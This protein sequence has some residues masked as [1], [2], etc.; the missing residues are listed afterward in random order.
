MGHE[1]LILKAAWLI[2]QKV[3]LSV[4]QQK[5]DF[6]PLSLYW[7]IISIISILILA[8]PR[9]RAS[10]PPKHHTW[11]RNQGKR[12]EG[13]TVPE[14]PIERSYTQEF[15]S[16]CYG[17]PEE[18]KVPPKGVLR[19]YII[20][21]ILDPLRHIQLHGGRPASGNYPGLVYLH[22]SL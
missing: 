15:K 14:C 12:L 13:S 18:S 4:C 3:P 6:L 7:I 1:D 2:P 22:C 11:E 17:C 16:Y 8:L 20:F 5:A 19:Q 21:H 10:F 9:A